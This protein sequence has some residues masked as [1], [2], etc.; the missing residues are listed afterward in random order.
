MTHGRWGGWLRWL[1]GTVAVIG[2]SS[3]APAAPND[4]RDL[5]EAIAREIVA[6][7]ELDGIAWQEVS[8]V[9]AVDEDGDVNQSY[10]YAYAADGTPHAVAFLYDPVE[11]AVRR[12]REWL[13]PR[14]DKGFIKMLFQFNRITRKVNAEFEYDD[15]ARWQVT[16]AN[17]DRVTAALRPQ[18]GD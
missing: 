11:Q 5:M 16:P 15:A 1:A 18:L 12:Y 10:G 13:R 4:N 17:V 7:G 2:L 6:C 9:F 3:A 14:H 8:A